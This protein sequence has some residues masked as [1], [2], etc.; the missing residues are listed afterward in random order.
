MRPVEDLVLALTRT[1]FREDRLHAIRAAVNEMTAWDAFFSQAVAWDAFF[2]QAAAWEVEPV[3]M[4]NLR[5]HFSDTLAEPILKRAAVREQHARAE[6]LS[7]T[8][9]LVDLANRF[10]YRRIDLIILKG[11][12]VAV[13]A[14]GNPSLRTFADIDLL[15]RKQ[16]LTSARDLLLALGYTRDYSPS[17]E[18]QLISDQHALEFSRENI[19]VELH[20]ALLEKH[21]RFDISEAELWSTSRLVPCAGAELRVL[22]PAHLFMF[23]C[24][25][26][27]KHEWERIRWICDIVQLSERLDSGE[28]DAVLALAERANAKRILELAL[29]V[30]RDVIGEINGPFVSRVPFSDPKAAQLAAHV[31][32][33]L[34]LTE[35]RDSRADWTARLDFRLRPLIFWARSRERR[36]DQVATV[37]R[38]FFIPT[39]NDSGAGLFAWISRPLRLGRRALSNVLRSRKLRSHA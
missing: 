24:A 25:H 12:A 26:G 20:W 37:A 34:G 3:V 5:T 6:A 19:K 18:Q 35:K 30:A 15:V 7:R 21:L 17:S 22:G 36:I 10:T 31:L 16:D 9:V 11:P 13:A 23:L 38:V 27:T 14:Y 1:P 33:R 8:L 39:E 4:S 2:L 32:M 28:A 29:R